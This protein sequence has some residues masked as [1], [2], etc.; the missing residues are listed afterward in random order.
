M[1][2]RVLNASPTGATN[3]R[4]P[5]PS[6]SRLGSL[7][8]AQD[9]TK[10]TLGRLSRQDDCSGRELNPR[11]EAVYCLGGVWDSMRRLPESGL[12]SSRPSMDRH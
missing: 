1:R 8:R 12:R 4:E 3:Q 9:G 7:D 10:Q 2:K 6:R 5:T 11:R